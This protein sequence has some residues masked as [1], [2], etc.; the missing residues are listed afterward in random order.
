MSEASFVV[1]LQRD[2]VGVDFTMW[3]HHV[4]S[5]KRGDSGAIF[6]AAVEQAYHYRHR[7]SAQKAAQAY[8]GA[9]ETV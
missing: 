4:H 3:L 9:V 8:G 7:A 5:Y 6:T 1:R 2:I